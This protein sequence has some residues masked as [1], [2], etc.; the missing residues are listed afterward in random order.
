MLGMLL[1]RFH[2][3]VV[4]WYIALKKLIME[5]RFL[6]SAFLRMQRYVLLNGKKAF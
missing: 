1:E 5:C 6:H 2:L 4:R 3:P